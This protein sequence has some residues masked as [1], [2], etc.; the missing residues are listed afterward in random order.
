MRR[1]RRRRSLSGVLAAALLLAAC[2]SG[3]GSPETGV[4]V[5]PAGAPEA[6]VA[7]EVTLLHP[8]T[9]DQ[10]LADLR[11]LLAA[12]EAAQPGVVVREEAVTDLA[13]VVEERIASGAA[14]DVIVAPSPVLL[15][16]LAADG[17][18]LPLDDLVDR[19]RLD[20][21]LVPGLLDLGTSDGT[22][23]GTLVA[24][25]LR[26]S[27]RSLVWYSPSTF[28]D[29]GHA[30]PTTWDE[31]LALGETMASDG[32]APWCIGIESGA[33]TGW[34][35]ADWVEDVILRALGGVEYDR[36]VAG[37]LPF[38]DPAVQRALEEYMVPIWSEGSVFGGRALLGEQPFNLAALGILGEDPDCGMHRQA[39]VAEQ[40]ILAAV[41]DAR[42]G[43]DYDFFALPPV[44]PGEQPMIGAAEHVAVTNDDPTTVAFVRYLATAEAGASWSPGGGFFSP[45]VS[46]PDAGP[47]GSSIPDSSAAR[48]SELLAMVTAFRIDGSDQMPPDVGASALPGSFWS[49]MAA[50]ARDERPLA[51][52]L[53]NID[54]RFARSR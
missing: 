13:T 24:I 32:L 47:D 50:W 27:P 43:V 29:G 11:A 2:S 10:D 30:I 4:P 31:L 12:F 36:W 39:L 7:G 5:D 1:T 14:P 18:V 41:P 22:S 3:P 26:V 42:F 52:A 9:R 17:V 53:A 45:F 8:F 20:A 25:P 33:A 16:D 44:V 46:V 49:E 37:E 38:A 51:E 48:A 15:R 21:A 23:E 6:P 40:L 28:A 19:S 35:V 54:E 34:V